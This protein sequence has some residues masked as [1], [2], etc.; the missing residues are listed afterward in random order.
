MIFFIHS[1]IG[2]KFV[3]M[4][5]YR[6]KSDKI[7]GPG[8]ITC[9]CSKTEHGCIFLHDEHTRS[10]RVAIRDVGGGFVKT[11]TLHMDSRAD[12]YTL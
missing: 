5:K 3:T 7:R 4:L 6:S 8:I 12:A 2:S 10:C 1:N 11:E 9:W